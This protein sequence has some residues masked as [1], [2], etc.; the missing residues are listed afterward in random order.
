MR[1][2]PTD[3]EL[4]RLIRAIVRSPRERTESV[5]TEPTE[6]CYFNA[7]GLTWDYRFAFD[8]GDKATCERLRKEWA[9][10]DGED[11]LDE[12]ADGEPIEDAEFD[13]YEKRLRFGLGAP[14]PR[15]PW[16]RVDAEKEHRER[17]A[18]HQRLNWLAYYRMDDYFRHN[19]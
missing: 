11:S 10:L 6:H 16:L 9:D 19:E 15:R 8:A 4:Q 18:L 2:G 3:A 1:E 7:T 5:P 13:D 12:C 17:R 14:S